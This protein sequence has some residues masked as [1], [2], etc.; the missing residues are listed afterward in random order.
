MHLTVQALVLRVT[1][2]KDTDAI[3]TLLSRSHGK[4]TAK[5]RGLR[6]KNN[7]M[8][9]ACQLLAYG[10]YTLFEYNG[11][12]TVNEA[13]SIEL[14]KELQKDLINLTLGT[15]F[16]QVA[17]VISQEDYPNPELLSLVLNS[18]YALTKLDVPAQ[19][20]KSVFEMRC[21]CIAGYQ[22]DLHGCYR[23]NTPIPDRFNIA[24]G[25]LECAGCRDTTSDG[26]RIPIT[27]GTVDALR[28]IC[29]CDPKKMFAFQ[30]GEET[31]NCLSQVSECF[32]SVQLER[33]F[34]ALDFY[35]ALQIQVHDY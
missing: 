1:P 23:C 5:A 24:E 28:Y 7:P 12:Y 20:V 29:F 3:L 26:I 6:R 30:A 11:Y 14:F 27:P 8:A 13:Q 4:I 17:D 10:E 31:L 19:R 35:N 33:G 2:Y 22:P 9:A 18:L 32:L 21:A 25:H 15:Y 16:V 34:S